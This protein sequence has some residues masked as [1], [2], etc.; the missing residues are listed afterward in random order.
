MG[1]V[2]RLDRLIIL[3]SEVQSYVISLSHGLVTSKLGSRTELSRLLRAVH[4]V[5]SYEDAA[6][7]MSGAQRAGRKR[8]KGRPHQAPPPPGVSLNVS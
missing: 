5:I 1:G 7:V 4:V 6:A 3:R 8:R 2:A